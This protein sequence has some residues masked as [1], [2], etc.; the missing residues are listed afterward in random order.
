MLGIFLRSVGP[1]YEFDCEIQTTA[2]AKTIRTTFNFNPD[3]S[4]Y[5]RKV[6]NTNPTIANS[7]I[8]PSATRV[9]YWLGETFETHLKQTVSETSR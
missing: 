7:A 6:F 1:A 9:N 5:I 2:G 8:T 4:K 3:S